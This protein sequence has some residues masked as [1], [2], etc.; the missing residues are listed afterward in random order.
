MTHNTHSHSF[1]VSQYIDSLQPLP[2]TVCTYIHAL[3]VAW[4]PV[5]LG[6]FWCLSDILYCRYLQLLQCPQDVS[7][8]A[9]AWLTHPPLSLQW[10][11]LILLS[12]S[13]KMKP[14]GWVSCS[15]T[16]KFL[17]LCTWCYCFD[18]SLSVHCQSNVLRNIVLVYPICSNTAFVCFVFTQFH[19]FIWSNDANG[20]EWACM[21]YIKG[22]RLNFI[23]CPALCSTHQY[24]SVLFRQSPCP[25]CLM[26]I[27]Q[28]GFSH[29]RYWS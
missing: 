10:W 11:S 28:H 21:N 2:A 8:M 18:A 13:Q 4:F 16:V 25:W 9:S 27:P 20:P 15:A 5:F 12:I 3:P 1:A 14:H 19:G 29:G 24:T 7:P 23:L 6:I 17:F 22:P 26:W